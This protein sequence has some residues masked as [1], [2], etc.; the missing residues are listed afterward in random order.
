MYSVRLSSAVSTECHL[1]KLED[2]D[3]STSTLDQNNSVAGDNAEVD[4]TN[5]EVDDALPC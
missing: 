5:T 4:G 1:S 2:I 3:F